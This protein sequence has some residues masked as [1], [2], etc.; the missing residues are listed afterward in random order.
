MALFPRFQ[1][2]VGIPHVAK[3]AKA[4]KVDARNCT[5]AANVR[6]NRDFR[7]SGLGHVENGQKQLSQNSQLS[8][9]PPCPGDVAERAAI[10][11]DGD[12]CDCREA[13]RNA[14]NG[15]G[16][17]SWPALAA[18]HAEVILAELNRLPNAIDPRGRRLLETTQCFLGSGFWLQ[19]IE[20]GWTLLEILDRKSVV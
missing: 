2:S 3:V 17:P 11:A 5:L 18:A 15:V 16:C 19:A 14:L 20:A 12:G 7:G 4:A 10:I 13:E 9:T 6:N 1:P 8:P